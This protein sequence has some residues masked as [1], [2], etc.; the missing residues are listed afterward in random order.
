MESLEKPTE[1]E[2]NWSYLAPV[3]DELYG[4]VEYPDPVLIAEEMVRLNV[5]KE[6]TIADVGCGTGLLGKELLSKDFKNLVGIDASTKMLEQA[7]AKNI[8]TSLVEHRFGEGPL[9][10]EL[11]NKFDVIVGA[12]IF[13]EDLMPIEAFDQ[14]HQMIPNSAQEAHIIISGRS[15]ALEAV[16]FIEKFNELEKEKKLCVVSKRTFI[17]YKNAPKGMMKGLEE[18]EAMIMV[19]KKQSREGEEEANA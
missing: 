5:R 11:I 8:Y 14:F 16:P 19:F 4:L 1:E 6:A 18:T 13:S 15:A 9:A 7:R 3:Y 2:D 10:K 12:S 17:R